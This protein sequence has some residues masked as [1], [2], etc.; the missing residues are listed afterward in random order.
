MK[1]RF[2]IFDLT[3]T[4][5]D[6]HTALEDIEKNFDVPFLVKSG[7][8]VSMEDFKKA[9]EEADKKIHRKT[10]ESK[11]VFALDLWTKII[12]EQLGV[13]YSKKLS[14]DWEAEFRKYMASRLKLMEGAKE[15][16]DYL[17]SKN[18]GLALF[19]NSTRKNV[20]KSLK[21][22]ES[23]IILTLFSFPKKSAQNLQSSHSKS[24]LKQ[25]A[26]KRKNA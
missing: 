14:E 16:L 26:R 7:F 3:D 10:K 22:S 2:V 13:P 9:R 23:E 6:Q 18:Y 15:I 24:L 4:L 25:S 12:C 21:N 19:S 17:K 1:I 8:S 5:I 11:G 20:K